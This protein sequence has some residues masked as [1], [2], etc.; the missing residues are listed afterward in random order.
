MYTR[1]RNIM[2]LL[3]HALSHNKYKEKRGKESMLKH[4]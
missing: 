2:C 1:L 4:K 3:F